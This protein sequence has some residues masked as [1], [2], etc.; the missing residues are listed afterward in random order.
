[1]RFQRLTL[2]AACLG[3]AFAAALPAAEARQAPVEKPTTPAAAKPAATT[4]ATAKP[5][6]QVSPAPTHP[7]DPLTASEITSAV[8]ILRARTEMVPGQRVLPADRAERAAEGRSPRLQARHVLPPRSRRRRLRS[9]RQP[10]VRG[11]RRSPHEGARDDDAGEGRA[12]GDHVRGV[13]QG[14]AAGARASGFRGGDEEARH[15]QRQRRAGRS[16]GARPARSEDRAAHDALGARAGVSERQAEQRL[17][18]ADRRRGRR[19]ST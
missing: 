11:D 3:L 6:P 18:A 19:S 13:R 10:H 1:M 15:H 8:N 12:A 9:R 2:P 5:R 7:L 17:R 14:A 4:P 16:V